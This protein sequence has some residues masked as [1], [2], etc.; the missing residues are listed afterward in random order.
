MK[1]I[2]I[3]VSTFN[4][5]DLTGIT[6]DSIARCK[7]PDSDVL[8]LD[9]NSDA[10]DTAWLNRWGWPVER[11]SATLGVGLAAKMRY[12]RF[13]ES[14]PHYRYLCALDNDLV[15]AAHFDNRMRQLWKSVK[16][17][18]LPPLLTVLTGYRSVTQ[19]VLTS[20][21]DCDLV[22]GVGGASQFVDRETAVALMAAM[23]EDDWV[24]NWDHRISRV[25]QRKIAVKYSL[26]QHLGTH[27][28]GVNGVSKDV[29]LDFVG[30]N[31]F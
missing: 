19:T 28:S 3:V 11:R 18:E 21:I 30:E 26:I 17:S 27:G 12:V 31:R 23:P 15:L 7:S 4:R 29:A 25:F 22:D 6:L 13:I 20:H 14:D 8:V 24:H 5:R 16:Q 9:D 2:L 1:D 10:Y